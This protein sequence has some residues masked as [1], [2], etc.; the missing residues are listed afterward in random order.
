MA[1]FAG[2][3]PSVDQLCAC[4]GQLPGRSAVKSGPAAANPQRFSAF[5]A[6]LR[7]E[8]RDGPNWLI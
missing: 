7:N 5:P 1:C 8:P 3:G 2:L 6:A 4:W